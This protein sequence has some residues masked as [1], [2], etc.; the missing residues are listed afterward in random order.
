MKQTLKLKSSDSTGVQLFNLNNKYLH[1]SLELGCKFYNEALFEL[2]PST[3]ESKYIH[4]KGVGDD[5]IFDS[6]NIDQVVVKISDTETVILD[7]VKSSS[8]TN[9]DL[10]GLLLS[11]LLS[12]RA[13]YIKRIPSSSIFSNFNPLVM[14]I[15][16]VDISITEDNHMIIDNLVWEEPVIRSHPTKQPKLQALVINDDENT[17]DSIIVDQMRCSGNYSE[18]QIKQQQTKEQLQNLNN[19]SIHK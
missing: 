3:K 5:V 1:P 9:A 15:H 19:I 2:T 13:E 11:A 12:K 16:S 7:K 6:I 18:H 4:N 17:L 10:C 14:E 8:Y